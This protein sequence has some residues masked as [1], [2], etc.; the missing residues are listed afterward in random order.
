MQFATQKY[1][2]THPFEVLSLLS[3]AN[4]VQ[5]NDRTSKWKM[6]LALEWNG[7]AKSKVF[8]EL[9]PYLKHCMASGKWHGIYGVPVPETGRTSSSELIK[10]RAELNESDIR[11]NKIET[12]DGQ[13]KS[14]WKKQ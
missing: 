14:C 1:N 3:E 2:S 8:E 10:N 6:E 5:R 9:Y 4:Y 12:K 11:V 7:R 13:D